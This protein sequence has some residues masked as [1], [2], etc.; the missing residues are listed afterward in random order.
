MYG[1]RPSRL[2]GVVVWWSTVA[3]TGSVRRILPDGCMDLMSCGGQLV[4][5]GPDA[6]AFVTAVQPGTDYIGLRFPPGTGPAFF[7]V[8][9]HELR[10]LRVPL[11]ELW[12]VD[13]VRRLA[14]LLRRAAD[15]GVALEEIAA[16]ARRGPPDRL[17]G[18]VVARLR[19]GVPVAA[20]ADAV[21]L[22]ERQ[23]RRRSLAAFGY[24]P[25]TLVRILRMVR[26][27]RLARAGIPST[28]V[29]A[30][31]GYADQ[32]HLSREVKALA[33]VPLGAL[34]N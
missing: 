3:A 13:E 1:E 32:A 6:T 19:A 17:I 23:L 27:L 8:P 7:G 22:G 34:L 20:T 11:E 26:A 16:R 31:A 12:P 18:E 9:A 10:G 5:A 21:G 14:G 25:K 2:A 30:T 33:G 15:P 24:G 28:T 4:V 29:A